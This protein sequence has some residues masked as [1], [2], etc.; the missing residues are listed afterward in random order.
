MG[1][2]SDKKDAFSLRSSYD[3]PDVDMNVALKVIGQNT[4]TGRGK[5]FSVAK[6]FKEDN[7]LAD[8]SIYLK[9]MKM[10]NYNANKQEYAAQI[11]IN[12]DYG[13]NKT[14]RIDIEAKAEDPI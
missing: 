7:W 2:V 10:P 12:L 11:G 4:F 1:D 14:P 9:Q 5:K 6:H 8:D 13:K 3:Y